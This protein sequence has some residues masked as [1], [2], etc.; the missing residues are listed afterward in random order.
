MIILR[1]RSP[2]SFSCQTSRVSLSSLVMLTNM[3]LRFWKPT[4]LQSWLSL[5]LFTS[6]GLNQ[7][8]AGPVLG[9]R[10]L[11]ATCFQARYNRGSQQET[12]HCFMC[13]CLMYF[14]ELSKLKALSVSGPGSVSFVQ[15]WS[16]CGRKLSLLSLHLPNTSLTTHVYKQ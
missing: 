7:N 6:A 8:Q 11:A 13:K 12:L 9:Q 14:P 15:C 16:L 4:T 5:R 2:I 3:T 10:Y 1:Y